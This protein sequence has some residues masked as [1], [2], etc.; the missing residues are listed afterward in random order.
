[1][2]RR[3]KRGVLDKE[4]S[5]KDAWRMLRQIDNKAESG[6]P[7]KA[8]RIKGKVTTD[9]MEIANHMNTHFIQ[10]VENKVREM[11][12]TEAKFCPVEHFKNSH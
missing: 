1:M 7:P 10:K 2:L 12:M 3:D 8:L 6:G 11:E 5:D 9:E 4:G